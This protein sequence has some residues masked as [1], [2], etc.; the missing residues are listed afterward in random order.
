MDVLEEILDGARITATLGGPRCNPG[1]AVAGGFPFCT[2]TEDSEVFPTERTRIMRRAGAGSWASVQDYARA[3]TSLWAGSSN[4]YMARSGSILKLDSA[5]A[6][7]ET[8]AGPALGS[9][10]HLSL[11]GGAP[12]ILQAA[13]LWS[14]SSTLEV[15]PGASAPIGISPKSSTLRMAA[16]SSSKIWYRTYSGGAPGALVQAYQAA[17]VELGPFAGNGFQ[18]AVDGTIYVPFVEAGADYSWPRTLRVLVGNVASPETWSVVDVGSVS[19]RSTMTLVSALGADQRTLHIFWV[20]TRESDTRV[21]ECWHAAGSGS[22][23]SAP[24]LL[25][26]ANGF[27][28]EHGDWDLLEVNG[29]SPVGDRIAVLFTLQSSLPSGHY[30][31]FYGE[32]PGEAPVPGGTGAR[33]RGEII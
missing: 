1:P 17:G 3:D 33:Y 11:L 2:I 14:P 24:A 12:V 7:V 16:N 18:I 25:I 20:V 27:P 8:L 5:G 32:A 26:D 21:E 23:F 29:A 15:F 10:F 6:L 4:L 22:T 9:S 28:F 19:T 13:D 31:A 30:H